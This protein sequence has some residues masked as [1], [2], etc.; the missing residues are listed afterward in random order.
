MY[1]VGYNRL[2][3]QLAV[4]FVIANQKRQRNSRQ[5]AR[6]KKN[7]GG[8]KAGGGEGEGAVAAGDLM[9]AGKK[10]ILEAF[11]K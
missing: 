7:V 6:N 4:M 11:F 9:S 1:V 10:F 5:K 8:G 2:D 3:Q